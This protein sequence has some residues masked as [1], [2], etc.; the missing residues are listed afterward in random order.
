MRS[1]V[2]Y[3]ALVAVMMLIVPIVSSAQFRGLGRVTGTVAD[4]GG[5]PLKDVLI[6]A[7]MN[8]EEGV[9][10]ERT[11]D[12]GSWAVNGMAKGEWHL[13]FQTPGYVPVAAKVTLSAELARVAPISVVLK[14]VK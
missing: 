5:S 2:R 10:E 9:I 14:K 1:G 3:V 6:R 7:T 13:T 4:D 8:G 12:K 11:D